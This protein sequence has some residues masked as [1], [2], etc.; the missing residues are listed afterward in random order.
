[1]K[2]YPGVFFFS[3]SSCSINQALK[4]VSGRL[5]TSRQTC[6]E[7]SGGQGNAALQWPKPGTAAFSGPE[8]ALT[9]LTPAD[10]S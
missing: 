2:D 3:C 1:M 4:Q 8:K 6:K 7:Q 10:P 5:E 9:Q